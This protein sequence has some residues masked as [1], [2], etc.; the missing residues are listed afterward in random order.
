MTYLLRST[1]DQNPFIRDV[2][3]PSSGTYC[4]ITDTDPEI[5]I[6]VDGACWRRV[7]EDHMSV[8]DVS[9]FSI[10]VKLWTF[11]INPNLW[12]KYVS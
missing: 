3:F 2:Y 1:S 4:N 11:T 12:L 8:Y 6:V 10:N 5:E 9:F 7:H